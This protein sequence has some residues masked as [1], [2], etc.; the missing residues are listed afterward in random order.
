[1]PDDVLAALR[2]ELILSGPEGEA[3]ERTVTGGE[4]LN[5]AASLGEWRI[6]AKAYQDTV[7]AGTGSVTL[8]VRTG[9]NSAQVPMNMTGPCYEITVDPGVAYGTVRS[10]FTAAFAGTSITIRAEK[11]PDAVF[12]DGS[13]EAVDSSSVTVAG[14]SGTS[15]TSQSFTMPAKDVAVHAG[16][17]QPVLYV[18]QGGAGS[19]DG[20]SW[21]NA[22]DDLQKM[23]DAHWLQSTDY[24][25][26][27]YIVKMGAGTYKPRW[28]PSAAGTYDDAGDTRDRTF[29]LREGVEVWGG[30]P[31]G[32]GDSRNVTGNVTTL[33]G[34]FGNNDTG[35][36]ATLGGNT[37]NAYHVVKAE[38]IP[39]ASGTVL[40]GLTIT[41]GNAEKS[42]DSL[43]GGMYNLNSS[44]VLKDVIITRNAAAYRGGGIYNTVYSSPVLNNVKISGNLARGSSGNEGGGGGG[45]IYSDTSSP[46]LNNVEISGNAATNNGGG[47]GSLRS[48][49]TLTNVTITGN[50]A[51]SSGGGIYIYAD[52]TPAP[53]VLKMIG[54]TV[55]G[56][57]AANGGGGIY[58]WNANLALINVTIA[59]NN[60]GNGNGG[61]IYNL[62]STGAPGPVLINM[63][64]SG[65]KATNGG[66]VSNS[67]FSPPVLTNVTVAGNYAAEKG[68]G[69][70]NTNSGSPK[71]YNSII[72][73]NTAT[74][75]GA[76]NVFT[77]SGTPTF[78]YSMVEGSGGSGVSWTF[79]P[80]YDHGGNKDEDPQF[81]SLDPAGS[82]S[83][84]T[85]GNY[86]LG[87][88]DPNPAV[89]AGLGT[90][91]P[92][93]TDDSIFVSSGLSA[94]EKAAINAAL[95]KDLGGNT[96][97]QDSN[98]D[99]G[100]Y[101]R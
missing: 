57:T 55:S 17:V 95:L 36:G 31:A 6:D 29:N 89:D 43:G 60:G 88:S 74:D 53:P 28:E 93:D 14:G 80:S 54:G 94:E 26:Y 48:T 61:G 62:G 81:V 2:Y 8:R 82:G 73:G 5:V 65:N 101:E 97:T 79:D 66:G 22:S 30:Y 11:G 77:D 4:S 37:E 39:A 98:I 21:E 49:P 40:D 85:G 63:L 33:S 18:R 91:Y 35:S 87:S 76:L 64:I 32:G 13:L 52:G 69:M 50:T 71:I 42:G 16:F 19:K 75:S 96:R 34:D 25:S 10:N 92:D 59:G 51:D 15:G 46:V 20:T 41:G 56:N 68:G 86:R 70:Y 45:G 47:M 1:L 67:D 100:A 9:T 23:M 78:A 99:M 27:T 38:N 72:W 83:P 24:S 7:L 58:N 90:D 44:P 12:I 3:L 84:K